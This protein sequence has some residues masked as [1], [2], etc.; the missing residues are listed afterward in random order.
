E[1]GKEQPIIMGSYGIGLERIIACAIEQHHDE[2]GICWPVTIA[3]YTVHLL[4]LGLHK[5][6]EAVEACKAIHDALEQ[7][8]IDV[9]FDDR[10]VSPGIK[11]NDADLIGLPLQ[12]IVGEKGIQQ[13]QLELKVRKSQERVTISIQSDTM[14]QQTVN[15][16]VSQLQNMSA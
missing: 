4:G 5:S 15:A 3:P 9:L 2:K 10:D 11:F 1:H 6:Q 7:L 16:I 8:G 12:L 14:I 13:G